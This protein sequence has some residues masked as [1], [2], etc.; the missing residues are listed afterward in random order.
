[1][2]GKKKIAFIG[3]GSMAEAMISGIVSSEKIAPKNIIVTNRSNNHRLEE[4]QKKYGITGVNRE[5]FNLNNVDIIVLAMKPKD[6]ETS[7]HS[8]F[9][10]LKIK[11]PDPVCFSWYNYHIYR[12]ACTIWSTSYTG[13]AKYI[14]V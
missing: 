2:L 10:T 1:M 3:A 12:T 14:S 5:N 9:D 6:V 4:L 11:S 7:L 8:I 13:Y